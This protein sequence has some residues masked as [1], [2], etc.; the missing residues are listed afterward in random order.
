VYP[1]APASWYSFFSADGGRTAYFARRGTKWR[2]VIDGREETEFEYFDKN[3]FLP[4]AFSPNGK[5]VAYLARWGQGPRGTYRVVI[6]G[7]AGPEYEA[8]WVTGPIFSPDSRHTAYVGSRDGRQFVVL[9]GKELEPHDGVDAIR[10][11][12]SPDSQRLAYIAYR[13]KDGSQ[14]AHFV[15]DGQ[16]GA[17]H[18]DHIWHTCFSP[19]SKHA[20]YIAINGRWQDHSHT[21][22]LVVDA[23]EGPVVGRVEETSIRW[24]S[25]S[26]HL[27][28]VA[29]NNGSIYVTPGG[30][31][32][33]VILDG[34]AQ[35]KYQWVHDLDFSADGNQLAY[36]AA[37]D[38]R[39]YVVVRNGQ[40]GPAFAEI[41]WQ[42]LWARRTLFTPDDRHLCYEATGRAGR[43]IVLDNQPGPEYRGVLSTW[44][45]VG[46]WPSPID[47]LRRMWPPR[48]LPD[49]AI[50]YPAV[51]AGDPAEVHIVTQW[52]SAEAADPVL[53][54]SPK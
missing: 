15:V 38:S 20:A 26:Q 14:K 34:K 32:M 21:E 37:P 13:G 51:T 18:G 30:Q 39:T 2:A 35:S 53:T 24:S 25:D 48:I 47:A 50:E 1:I 23:K 42:P 52:P 12:F 29:N 10:L 28:Y 22:Q 16:E 3:S 45:R 54:D 33:W 40:P 6:D 5:H 8:K 41:E 36:V 44:F 27:A 46:K 11:H 17:E 9:D 19:D 49:S 43:V 4:L 31:L 7:R